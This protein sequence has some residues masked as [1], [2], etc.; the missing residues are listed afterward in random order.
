MTLELKR[1]LTR[2]RMIQDKI[3]KLNDKIENAMEAAA[4]P[5]GG[6]SEI[7]VKG[8]RSSRQERY[9]IKVEDAIA[10]IR[11]L[12]IEYLDALERAHELLDQLEPGER[13]IVSGLYVC[14][15]EWRDLVRDLGISPAA[16][17]R[18]RNRAIERLEVIHD[19]EYQEQ[20]KTAM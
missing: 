3:S 14:G 13:C 17:A 11:E 16:M 15:R 5:S 19:T 12:Q 10:E 8:P 2:P 18:I 7:R 20:A 6:Y 4:L 9:I 1:I